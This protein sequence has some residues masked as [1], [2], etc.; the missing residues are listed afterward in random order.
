ML[1]FTKETYIYIDIYIYFLNA[2]RPVL[3]NYPAGSFWVLAHVLH[4]DWLV[5]SGTCELRQLNSRIVRAFDVCIFEL[6]MQNC[7]IYSDCFQFFCLFTAVISKGERAFLFTCL[8]LARIAFSTDWDID[9]N[10]R[11]R[12]IAH[13]LIAY[14][15]NDHSE[16]MNSWWNL[17]VLTC[18][19][20]DI[21]L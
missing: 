20:I 8:N 12:M 21:E 2:A 19:L 9:N 3:L 6:S 5:D 1:P 13:L 7:I 10:K 16:W 15:N 17:S 11:I 18:L 14:V 4:I